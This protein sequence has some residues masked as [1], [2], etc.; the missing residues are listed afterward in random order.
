[1]PEAI[2]ATPAT[3]APAAPSPSVAAVTPA[4]V[5]SPPAQPAAAP[6]APA[7]ASSP[8]P[9]AAGE[10][11]KVE[12]AKPVLD[13]SLIGDGTKPVDT[14]D[15][16]KPADPAK[17]AAPV[18]PNAPI[19]YDLKMPHG[20][21]VDNDMMGEATAIFAKAKVSPEVAQEFA[22]FHGNQLWALGQA[23]KD[24]FQNVK[25][26]ELAQWQQATIADKALGG[27]RWITTKGELEQGLRT[28]F[29]VDGTPANSPQRAEHE[30]F[31]KALQETRAG[32]RIE[33]LRGLH[34]MVATRSEGRP[35]PV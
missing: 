29:G 25:D 19:V 27:Q 10:P 1:M 33:I 31:V 12:P 4:A 2:A 23:M 32:S 8:P 20:I 28:V 15:P 26:T 5:S 16:A 7:A 6:T 14:A 35:A 17:D 13:G 22:T 9:A 21:E 11:A 30:A 18:D 3:P 34:K 24:H